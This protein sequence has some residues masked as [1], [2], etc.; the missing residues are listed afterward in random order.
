[1]TGVQTCALPIYIHWGKKGQSM[2]SYLRVHLT[3]S[4]ALALVSLWGCAPPALVFSAVR[5]QPSE[6]VTSDTRVCQQLGEQPVYDQFVLPAYRNIEPRSL[7]VQ[8][9]CMTGIGYMAFM[10]RGQTMDQFKADMQ[11]CV[12]TATK[13]KKAFSNDDIKGIAECM[14]GRGYDVAT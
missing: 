4:G 6:Q 12:P 11:V 14:R 5:G 8:I 7:R 10:T 9:N 2:E 1:M 3:V 13:E